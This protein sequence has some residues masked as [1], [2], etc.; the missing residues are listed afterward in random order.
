MR[1]KERIEKMIPITN[2]EPMHKSIRNEV[3]KAIEKVYDSNWFILGAE[4]DNFEKE[5]ADYCGVK[6]A[7][8]VGNGLDALHLILKAYEIGTGD[9]VIIPSNTFIATA[10]AVSYV[11]ATPVLV[12]PDDNTYNIDCNLIEQHITERTKA[13]IAVHLYGQP[14]DMDAIKQ[15]AKENNLVVIEDAAQAHGAYYKNK[16][17]GSLGNAAG[18]SFYPGKNLGALGDG[19]IVTTNDENLARTIREIRNYGSIEKYVHL[20]K[21]VN[22][23]LDELQCAILRIKLRYLDKWNEERREIAECYR[24]NLLNSNKLVLPLVPDW[25]IPVWHQFVIRT[26]QRDIVQKRL[27]ENKI[28]TLVH[29]PIPIHMQEAYKELKLNGTLE[30]TEKLANEVLSLPIWPG[31]SKTQ[32]DTVCNHLLND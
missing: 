11:G 15:I 16:K 2:L 24:E 6:Y 26:E 5:F 12:E 21:G 3:L 28:K 1:S 30:L 31:M 13:I 23:R 7:V 32:I 17:V 20:T 27:G 8:G 19:G 10:L 4:V 14:A 25:A 9:E 29:Y 22:S 18:F